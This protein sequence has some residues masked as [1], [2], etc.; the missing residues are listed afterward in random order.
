M[1]LSSLRMHC[2]YEIRTLPPFALETWIISLA[3]VVPDTLARALFFQLYRCILDVK[4]HQTGD[5]TPASLIAMQA[6][7]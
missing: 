4:S 5:K 1:R 2:L 7:G 3:G 6:K